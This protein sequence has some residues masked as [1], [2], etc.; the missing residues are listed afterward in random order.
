MFFD[1]GIML[2]WEVEMAKT[3]MTLVTKNVAQILETVI[4]R[5]SNN[6]SS[7]FYEENPPDPQDVLMYTKREF[8]KEYLKRLGVDPFGRG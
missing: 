5:A 2:V 3:E 8:R 4:S 1:C 7:E 6:F